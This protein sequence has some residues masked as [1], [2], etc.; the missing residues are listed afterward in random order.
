MIGQLT[1]ME[2]DRDDRFLGLLF[3]GLG[4]GSREG[5]EHIDQA[6][7]M[8][9]ASPVARS[10]RAGVRQALAMETANLE[11][12]DRA[13]EDAV[14]A[15][16]FLPDSPGV[17]AQ[18]LMSYLVRA[19]ILKKNGDADG[20]REAMAVARADASKLE[21]YPDNLSARGG[22]VSFGSVV[23]LRGIKAADSSLP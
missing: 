2:P 21:M 22:R 15:V 5:L 11:E 14:A 19:N 16:S 23:G 18:H 12:A 4:L 9:P 6:I 3:K 10:I 7:A 1:R 8:R 13:I 17:I 20:Y